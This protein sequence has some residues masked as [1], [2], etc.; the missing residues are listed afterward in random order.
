MLDITKL[1]E[2]S[3]KLIYNE[4]HKELINI[5]TFLHS[6]LNHSEDVMEEE[7]VLF[8]YLVTKIKNNPVETESITWYFNTYF[9]SLK[10]A[11][12]QLNDKKDLK[13]MY[14]LNAIA[15]LQYLQ[16]IYLDK[17]FWKTEEKIYIIKNE[18]KKELYLLQGEYYNYIKH[19]LYKYILWYWRSYFNLMYT[20]MVTWFTFAFIYYINDITITINN[21]TLYASFIGE[22]WDIVWP[23]DYYLYL[24]LSTLSNLWADFWLWTTPY[25][26]IMFWIEQMLWVI[27]TWLFVYVLAKKI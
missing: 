6:E 17:Y 1:E 22:T 5:E 26:R 2:I 8:L 25:L 16:K 7:Y 24:S 10:K 21:S 3:S 19:I 11:I 18:C 13:Q 14:I 20:A 9:Q 23:F 4:N 27:L 15:H 12:I